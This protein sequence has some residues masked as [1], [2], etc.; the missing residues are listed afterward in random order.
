MGG[1]LF[2]THITEGLITR[3]YKEFLNYIR[4]RKSAST[5]EEAIHL[6]KGKMKMRLEWE[7]HIKTNSDYQ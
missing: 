3:I 2:S 4:K 5:K 6:P 1:T 7:L